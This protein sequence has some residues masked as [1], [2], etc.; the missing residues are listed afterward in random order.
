MDYRME[1]KKQQQFVAMVR[2]FPNE[3]INDV[4]RLLRIYSL[5]VIPVTKLNVR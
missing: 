5:A 4:R 2:D 1:H 3:I